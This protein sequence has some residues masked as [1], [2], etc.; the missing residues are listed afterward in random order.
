M[1]TANDLNISQSGIVVFDG[2]ATFTGVTLTAGSG[3]SISNGSG[4][5]GNPTISASGLSSLTLTGD[6]GGALSPSGN[7]FNLSGSGSIA[8]SGSG[9][10]ITT[11]LSGLTNHAVLV[12][13]GTATITKV[14]PSA[15]TGQILQNNAAADPS[16]STATYPST[17]TI[18]QILYSNATSTVTGLATANQG[19]LTTGTTGVPVITAIAT[20]GQ[21]IIGSTAGAPAAAT[22]TAGTG[23][24]ITNASNSITIATASA[25]ALSF[26]TGSG[27]A[28]PSSGALT[29][30][31]GAN[32]NTSGSGSTVT[33]NVNTQILQP[34]GSAAA[35]SYSFTGNTNYGP[36]ITGSELRI[37]AAGTDVFRA[38]GSSNTIAIGPNNLVFQAGSIIIA[39]Q[40][41][42]FS[43][44]IALSYVAPSSWPYSLNVAS[45]CFVSVD[46]SAARTVKLPN[47]ANTTGIIYIIKDRVGSAATNNISVT[48]VGGTVT[49]DGVTTYTISTNYG[50]VSVIWNGTTYEIF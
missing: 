27:T 9:S 22:L 11:A 32:I 12:G 16:Y 13:A 36:Y 34:V 38:D 50:S 43:D 21:L 14:G 33:I 25:V 10:T 49:I 44:A 30:A 26:P 18:N 37:S 40:K 17:T 42:Q 6:S 39:Q 8:T 15:S 3:I 31:G 20:N 47:T 24:S 7:N 46:S 1:A 28:T 4:V 23:V 35:P 41:F 48:T 45:D 5:S 29:I 19:V 2:T